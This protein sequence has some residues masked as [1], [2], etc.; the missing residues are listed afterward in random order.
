[1]QNLSYQEKLQQVQ[2]LPEGAVVGSSL[3]QDILND[4]VLLLVLMDK[5]ILNLF[6]LSETK[7]K[8]LTYSILQFDSATLF[9]S[10]LAQKGFSHEDFHELAE[11]YEVLWKQK[12]FIFQTLNQ[13]FSSILHIPGQY[14]TQDILNWFCIKY[15][16]KNIM[17]MLPVQNIDEDLA[18]LLV[19]QRYDNFKDLP[20][21]LRNNIFVFETIDEKHH[22]DVYI[23]A[24][25]H[26]RSNPYISQ[27]VIT[28]QANLYRYVGEP[29]KTPEFFLR[30]LRSTYELLKYAPEHIKDNELC[31]W[32]SVKKTPHS[33]LYASQRL[34]SLPTFCLQLCREMQKNVLRDTFNIWSDS[35]K[36][37]EEVMNTLMEKISDSECFSYI[38]ETVRE[39]KDFM[40]R[41]VLYHWQNISF[42]GA[43]LCDDEHY[44]LSLMTKLQT[45]KHNDLLGKKVYE[46]LSFLPDKCFENSELLLQLYDHFR[47]DFEE[48]IYPQIRYKQTDYIEE[49]NNSKMARENG[50][51]SFF[52]KIRLYKDLEDKLTH[53]STRHDVHKI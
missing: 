31:V 33:L 34:L 37:N 24:G 41:S 50:I 49:M 3:W 20:E 35:I 14:L 18:C 39:S 42:L 16:E 12:S 26:I 5:K 21:K 30:Q 8:E 11:H 19:S 51:A 27:K 47:D 7:R 48:F 38:G 22:A 13:H 40:T 44:I 46:F 53:N 45:R 17:S 1:M 4:E 43:K 28:K 52:D 15:S 25:N 6:T 23:Y 29:L 9:S 2:R 10:L 36:N 32:E